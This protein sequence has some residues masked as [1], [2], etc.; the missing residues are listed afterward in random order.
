ML[1]ETKKTLHGQS[2]LEKEKKLEESYYT[3]CRL[4]YK[5]IILKIIWYWQKN[6]NIDKKNRKKKKKGQ[7]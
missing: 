3:L 2:N 6:R 1:M 5:A 7:K 4:F